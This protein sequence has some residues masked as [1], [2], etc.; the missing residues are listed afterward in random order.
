MMRIESIEDLNKARQDAAMAQQERLK[1]Q[2]FTVRVG[3]SSCGIAAGAR[4]TYTALQAM[5]SQTEFRSVALE[6]I[7]CIGLCALE[8]VVQV[9][10]PGETL[11]TYGKVTPEV[12]RR[13]LHEHIGKGMIVQQYKV[14]NI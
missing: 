11:V 12:A 10:I 3:M 7:G 2:R 14:E 4:D 8:P 13:I 1:I 5:V 9:L 6:Q